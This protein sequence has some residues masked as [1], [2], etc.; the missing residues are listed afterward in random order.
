MTTLTTSRRPAEETSDV[1][2]AT[3]A[4]LIGAPL[5]MAIGRVLLVPLDDQN[6]DSVLTSMANHRGRS[7]AGWLLALAASGL[8]GATAVMLAQRLSVTGRTRAAWFAGIT[9]AMGWA[10]TAAVCAGSLFMAE[11]AN[12]PDRAVQIQL[13][14][15]FNH[16]LTM[17]VM[18][19]LTLLAGAG[20]VVLAVGLA[21]S[22][23]VT[24]GAAVLVGLGG[25]TTL[26]TMAGP[27]TVLLVLTALLL[28]VGHALASRST[29][30]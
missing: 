26:V 18:F 21:R 23:L 15:D 19:L 3:R 2:A 9:A 14:K 16:S 7:D 20:Y 30:V 25:L 5:A 29:A 13:L 8:L 28:A 6:W 4:F 27:V 17:G 22:G 24:K 11:M 1:S 12:A 10:C